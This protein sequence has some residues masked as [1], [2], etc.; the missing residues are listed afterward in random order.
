MK[1]FLAVTDNDWFRFLRRRPEVDEVNFWQPGGSREFKTLK[2]GQPM[3][4]KLHSPEN[5]VVGGGFLVR[6]SLLPASLAWAAFGEKNGTATWEEMRAGRLC[7]CFTLRRPRGTTGARLL[8]SALPLTQGRP[9]EAGRLSA[10]RR[11]YGGG[12]RSR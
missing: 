9:V 10:T 2:P 7:V 4:F 1:L 12:E 5:F 11:P 3:L 8:S 6:A